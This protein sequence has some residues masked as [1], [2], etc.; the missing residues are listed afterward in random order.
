M[1][2]AAAAACA[3]WNRWCPPTAPV[4]TVP[5]PAFAATRWP[6]PIARSPAAIFIAAWFVIAADIADAAPTVIATDDAGGERD[7]RDQRD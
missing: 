2:T 1:S 7:Q 3:M 4:A 6:D 5:K